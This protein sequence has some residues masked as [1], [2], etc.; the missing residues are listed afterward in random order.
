MYHGAQLSAVLAIATA[1]AGCNSDQPDDPVK[2]GTGSAEATPLGVT[3]KASDFAFEAPD[4]ITAGTVTLL[5]ENHG[6]ELHQIQLV[7]LEDGKTVGDLAKAMKNHGALPSWIKWVGGPNGTAPGQR[8]NA[9]SVLEP[10]QYAYVCLIPSA[11]GKL[12]VAKGMV[13]PFQVTATSSTSAAELPAADVTIKLVDY[14]FEPSQPLTPGRHT[15]LVENAGPQPHE[16]VLIRLAPGKKVEDFARWAE[17]M[18]GPPPA[19]PV[20][21]V[22]ILEKAG[23]GMFTVDLTAGD[24]GFIC[25]VPDKK[26]AKYHFAHGMMKNF[27][28]S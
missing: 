23:Q 21:G 11:D 8:S 1:L 19:E 12:H 16:L 4:K 20:G 5:L 2:R 27:K 15:I 9:T 25:F 10:G 13:R 22:G 17:S 14:D 28:V 18:K 26:D 24:Y 6:K 7:R 3:I